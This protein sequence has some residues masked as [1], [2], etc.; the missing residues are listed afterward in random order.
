MKALSARPQQ[1]RRSG[2]REIL[3]LAVRIP[4][5]I[6]LEVGEP[7]FPTPSH[8]IE[9]AHEA[10]LQGHTRYTLSAGILP[11]RE[12][13]VEKMRRFNGLTNVKLE[14]IVVTPGSTYTLYNLFE[15]LLDPGDEVLLPDP[16]WP[17]YNTQVTLAGGNSV[18]YPLHAANGFQPVVADIEAQITPK[19]KA[20]IICNPSNPTGAVSTTEQIRDIVEMARRHDLYVISDEVYEQLIF[21]GTPTT[22]A[23]FDPERVIGIY[24]FSKTYSMTGWRIGYGVA[25]APIAALMGRVSE[26]NVACA[27]E[28]NQWAALAALNGPQDV[29]ETMRTAYQH[30]RDLVCDILREQGLLQYVPS[31]AFYIMIDIS[32]ANMDSYDFCKAFLQEKKVSCAPGATFG[33]SASGMV[34][35][36]LATAEDQLVEG[37]SRLCDF[38]AER[39]TQSQPVAAR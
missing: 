4:D 17:T 24:S 32:K 37:V 21:E 13:L 8:V 7:N 38:I 23:Q 34:R 35:V 14:N 36:S 28:P 11:L 20:V 27:A 12:A 29:V 9:A 19:T 30:R 15:V 31:G 33:A 6:R 26:P 5:C 2:I 39:A 10:A 22:A 16:G 1:M 18:F 25:P 3:E